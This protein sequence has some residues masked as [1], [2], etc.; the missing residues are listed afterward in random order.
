[1]L[2]I[3]T[4]PD[5]YS[6]NQALA[7]IKASLGDAACLETNTSVMEGRQLTIDNLKRAVETA[8]F[9]I[10]SRLVII[11]GLLERFQPRP[12][13]SKKTTNAEKTED[14]KPFSAIITAMPPSTVLVLIEAE[15]AERNP[16]LKA[17]T[18][19]ADVRSF[20]FLKG[21]A[22]RGWI[23]RRV[24]AGK[25][26]ISPGATALL[27]RMVGSDLWLMSNEISKLALYALGRRIEEEDVRTM[28][29]DD[30]Q[31]HIFAM[32]DAII[33][34]KADK[35][36]QIIQALFERGA[37]PAY[38]L[39]MLVRQA[40]LLVQ[41]R[42]LKETVKSQAELKSRLHIAADFA[43][44]K[45]LE[46]ASAYPLPRLTEL[47]R[48]LLE[49]DLAIKTGRYEGALAINILV[50]ELCARGS[51]AAGQR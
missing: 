23:E 6:I 12:A 50:A 38:M 41:A 21:E 20:P 42:Q 48:R 36:E 51:R 32:V 11:N 47:Y 2:Y 10:G 14:F 27:A 1:M 18:P 45:T 3:L 24:A 7:E 31:S 17:L 26:S 16:L 43:L 28:V 13:Q 5:D 44:R 34:G 15:L 29:S 9:L 49:A 46:Q 35:A 30:Q 8:P 4:G 39:F 25:S 22:L 40:R 37:A 19:K 33:A